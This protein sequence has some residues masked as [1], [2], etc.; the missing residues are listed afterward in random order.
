MQSCGAEDFA[1]QGFQFRKA[2]RV[3]RLP[4]A[5]LDHCRESLN[6]LALVILV[7]DGEA[8][9][10]FLDGEPEGALQDELGT[11]LAFEL[12]DPV[13]NV[14]LQGGF[15]SGSSIHLWAEGGRAE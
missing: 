4:R 10:A 8:G 11:E 3:W 14:E 9:A 15:D 6:A 13:A 2:E 1:L 5:L 12:S 7:L